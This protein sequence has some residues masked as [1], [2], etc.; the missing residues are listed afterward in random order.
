M[1]RSD[2]WWRLALWTNFSWR[3]PLK[4]LFWNHCRICAK[5]QLKFFGYNS[6]LLVRAAESR[7]ALVEFCLRCHCGART[8]RSRKRTVWTD[9]GVTWRWTPSQQGT[10]ASWWCILP[11][12]Q[13]TPSITVTVVNHLKVSPEWKNTHPTWMGELFL[14]WVGCLL[15]LSLG[16]L[17]IPMKKRGVPCGECR[18]KIKDTRQD[19]S[20]RNGHMS[21][22]GNQAWG[23]YLTMDGC[24]W[25]WQLGWSEPP[26][27][28]APNPQLALFSTDLSRVSRHV[29]VQDWRSQF[30]ATSWSRAYVSS[31]FHSFSASHPPFHHRMANP[32]ES[33]PENQKKN[34][35]KQNAV[36][37]VNFD[38]SD[39]K[40]LGSPSRVFFSALR[41]ARA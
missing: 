26:P 15:V 18:G 10:S 36:W 16:R 12:P 30:S 4:W 33:T 14:Q 37:A 32:Q 21:P 11:S 35:K 17:P 19:M 41:E 31:F 29:C 38:P 3:T 22:E 9:T 25:W 34:K 5:Q 6:C 8:L 2:V 39:R 1:W 20:D 13:A 40:T 27:P 23:E 7:A 28:H 24:V